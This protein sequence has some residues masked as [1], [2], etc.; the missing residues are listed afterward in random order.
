MTKIKVYIQAHNPNNKVHFWLLRK[1]K[2]QNTINILVNAIMNL[3]V[4]IHFVYF[5]NVVTKQIKNK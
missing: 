5:L 4:C 2:L 1:N 3:K